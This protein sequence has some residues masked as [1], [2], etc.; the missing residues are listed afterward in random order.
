M[1][2]KCSAKDL[3]EVTSGRV[4]DLIHGRCPHGSAWYCLTPAAKTNRRCH[5]SLE[6]GFP[7]QNIGF[8]TRFALCA[9][10]SS[11]VGFHSL[12]SYKATIPGSVPQRYRF[13]IISNSKGRSN[14]L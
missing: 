11:L 8:G 12:E 13:F 6:A 1:L 14:G 4:D 2:A 9:P 10:L 5:S 3:Q 7:L